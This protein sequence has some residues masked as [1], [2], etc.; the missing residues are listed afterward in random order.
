M[1]AKPGTQDSLL[2]C[3]PVFH[4]SQRDRWEPCPFMP[5]WEVLRCCRAASQLMQTTMPSV[6]FSSH[7][8]G[9][10]SILLYE[11]LLC[12]KSAQSGLWPLHSLKVPGWFFFAIF[13][14]L[15]QTLTRRSCGQMGSQLLQLAVCTSAGWGL[16]FLCELL[17]H[18]PQLPGLRWGGPDFKQL[19][20]DPTYESGVVLASLL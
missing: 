1:H 20:C 6:S 8:A 3:A 16:P 7:N 17:D 15:I 5:R 18:T 11:V 12:I 10:H 4:P 14:L 2:T 9:L 13:N 19:V